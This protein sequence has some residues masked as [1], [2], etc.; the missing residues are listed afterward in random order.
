MSIFDRDSYSSFLNIMEE[1]VEDCTT[2][3][4]TEN[5]LTGLYNA[6]DVVLLAKNEKNLRKFRSYFKR[7]AKSFNNN[8]IGD[9]LII[10]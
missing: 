1:K 6:N 3:D 9:R 10:T 2:K 7:K 5:Q 4:M 8:I